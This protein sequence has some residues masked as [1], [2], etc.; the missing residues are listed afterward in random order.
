M[1]ATSTIPYPVAAC[2]LAV[3]NL[4]SVVRHGKVSIREFFLKPEYRSR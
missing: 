1:D 4:S 2:V 3:L